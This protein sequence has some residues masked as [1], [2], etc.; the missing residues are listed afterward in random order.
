M[1][2]RCACGWGYTLPLALSCGGAVRDEDDAND[3]ARALGEDASADGLG[4]LG[5][6]AISI[7]AGSGGC[8]GDEPPLLEGP[9]KSIAVLVDEVDEEEAELGADSL[10]R[11]FSATSQIKD[12]TQI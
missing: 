5:E 7:E 9:S 1:L 4:A 6:L 10:E 3:G 8:D 2:I 11:A 12:L